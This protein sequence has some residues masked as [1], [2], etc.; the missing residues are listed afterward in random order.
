MNIY[1]EAAL[2]ADQ[3]EEIEKSLGEEFGMWTSD[4]MA[5][6]KLLDEVKRLRTGIEEIRD[7]AWEPWLNHDWQHLDTVRNDCNALLNQN[8]GENDGAGR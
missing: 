8:K 3:L 4:T 2:T 1:G 6:E 5:A 7:G